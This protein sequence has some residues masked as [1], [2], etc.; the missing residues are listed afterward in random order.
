VLFDVIEDGALAGPG[1]ADRLG[2]YRAVVLPDARCL[3]DG[4]V[5]ALDGYV[6]DGGRLLATGGSATR[7]EHGNPRDGIALRCLGL[8]RVVA[9]EARNRGL[10][11]RIS[12]EDKQRLSGFA[13]LDLLHLDTP[14]WL[15]EPAPG[16]AGLLS[17]VGPA[18]FGPP[19]KCYWTAEP[20]DPGVLVAA[21]GRAAYLPWLPGAA[22]AKFAH[23]GFATLIGSVLR[24][25]LGFVPRLV[26]GAPACVELALHERGD[27]GWRW[28]G[29]VNHPAQ[30]GTAH[31]AP[32]PVR[33]LAFELADGGA[34][35]SIRSLRLGTEMAPSVSGDRVSFVLP[36]LRDFDVI[37]IEPARS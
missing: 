22:Y 31:H 18:M 28:L 34:V 11:Y 20:G 15:V 17:R 12:P 14:F 26:T 29:L 4:A 13:D 10:Y 30:L 16:T 9:E 24:D 21:S 32:L 6:G 19:E 23:P 2:K 36:E 33:D 27:G 1:L 8:G 5:A 7:D 35:S 25:R 37:V 3:A